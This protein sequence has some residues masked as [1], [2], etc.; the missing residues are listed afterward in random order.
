MTLNGR[1]KKRKREKNNGRKWNPI[2]L[3]CYREAIMN[4]TEKQADQKD[5]IH[6]EAYEGLSFFYWENLSHVYYMSHVYHI[7]PMSPET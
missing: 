2:S 1:K 7:Q 5:Q 6:G 3:A 4:G